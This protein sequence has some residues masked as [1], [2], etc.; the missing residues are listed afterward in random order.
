MAL[1]PPGQVAGSGVRRVQLAPG[2]GYDE[3]RLRQQPQQAAPEVGH[4][5]AGDSARVL[6]EEGSW[7]HLAVDGSNSEGWAI[8]VLPDGRRAFAEAPPP[9]QNWAVLV[10]GG[11]RAAFYGLPARPWMDLGGEVSLLVTLGGVY[12]QLSRELGP[13]HVI[14]IAGLESARCWLRGMADRGYSI[15][16]D[17]K[18]L[19]AA[20]AFYGDLEESKVKWQRRL[21]ELEEAC[22]DLIAAGGADYDGADVNP[23]SVLEVLGGTGR[24]GRVLPRVGVSGLFLWVTTHGSSHPISIGVSHAPDGKMLPVPIADEKEC[25]QSESLD[26]NEWFWIMPHRASDP[27]AYGFVR[28]AGYTIDPDAD[29]A[30]E[31]SHLPLFV[32]YWQQVFEVLNST[33]QRDPGRRVAAFYQFCQAGGHLNF[34]QRPSIRQHWGVDR[35]PIYMMASAAANQTSLG[36]TLTNIFIERLQRSLRAGGREPLGHFFRDVEEI[37]WLRHKKI[38]QMNQALP[39]AMRMGEV[40]QYHTPHGGI[41]DVPVHSLFSNREAILRLGGSSQVFEPGME[42]TASSAGCC[43]PPSPSAS[44]SQEEETPRTQLSSTIAAMGFEPRAVQAALTAA[45]DQPDLAIDLLL[46]RQ[47]TPE[48]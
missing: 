2:S 8:D 45:G 43:V 12:S 19:E 35:W 29:P 42:E 38:A 18:H 34:L 6:A 23:T 7:L 41:Q 47:V 11:T 16:S 37:Y 48:S 20:K 31:H 13:E 28:L 33:L 32:V 17:P 21:E 14:V 22:A 4:V 15:P 46:D 26:A 3:W 5:V 40:R 9:G 27:A 39:A 44:S 24:A 30:A 36:G 10:C 1:P 25:E